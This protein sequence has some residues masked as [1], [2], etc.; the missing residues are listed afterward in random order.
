[1]RRQCPGGVGRGGTGW[2]AGVPG[3][4]GSSLQ[5][6]GGDRVRKPP[7]APRDPSTA[8]GCFGGGGV[9]SKGLVTRSPGPSSKGPCKPC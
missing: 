4:G 8:G 7:G 1:M 5:R 2:E 9:G 6:L 3:G